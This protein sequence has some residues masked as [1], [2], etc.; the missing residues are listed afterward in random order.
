MSMFEMDPIF[1]V[2]ALP[3]YLS[4]IDVSISYN[5][6]C[7]LELAVNEFNDAH[8]FRKIQPKI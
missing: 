4:D 3:V 2:P 5:P 6:W 1:Y 8:E 7:G